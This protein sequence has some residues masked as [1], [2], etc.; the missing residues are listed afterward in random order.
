CSNL[1]SADA[2]ALITDTHG[3]K[4]IVCDATCLVDGA[5]NTHCNYFG[6]GQICRG[7]GECD[8]DYCQPCPDESTP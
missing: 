2:E 7:C 5:D 1:S 6:L 4:R 3:V 8:N